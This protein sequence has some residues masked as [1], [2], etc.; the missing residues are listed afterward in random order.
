MDDG[1]ENKRVVGINAAVL[2][3][4]MGLKMAQQALPHQELFPYL[5]LIFAYLTV[6]IVPSLIITLLSNTF[7]EQ[8]EQCG[9]LPYGGMLIGYAERS[10]IFLAFLI[11]RYEDKAALSDILNSVS[12]IIAGKAIFDSQLR[13]LL[14]GLA[15]TGTSWAHF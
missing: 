13:T 15:L 4:I 7:K 9:G 12:F 14:G 2:V 1:K 3:I 10:L 5:H 6:L 11:L 8:I